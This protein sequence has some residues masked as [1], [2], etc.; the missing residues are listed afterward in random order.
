LGT[1]VA[2]THEER[3]RHCATACGT[4]FR[5]EHAALSWFGHF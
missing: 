3:V 5:I 2:L 1:T 4:L